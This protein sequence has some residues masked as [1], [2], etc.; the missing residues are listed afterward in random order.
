MSEVEEFS[1]FED[2]SVLE[3]RGICMA[4]AELLRKQDRQ[5]AEQAT[6]IDRL[7]AELAEVAAEVRRRRRRDSRNSGNSS[8]PPSSD[9]VLPGRERPVVTPRKPK[10][11]PRKRGRQPGAPGSALAWGEPT[12]VVDHRPAGTCGGCGTSLAGAG[13]DV[14]SRS[15]QVI[16]V[17]L[18]AMT[19][20][21]HRLHTVVCGCGRR[22]T[23]PTPAGTPDTRVSYGPNLPAL[24]VYL[25]VAHALPVE[26]ACQVIADLTG[27]RPS[28]SFAH[29]TLA[30]TAK[31]LAEPMAAIA[32]GLAASPVVHFDE[33]GLRVGP[34]PHAAQVWVAATDRY[35]IY[36]LAS[37]TGLAFHAWGL[38]K[39][40][41]DM[42]IVHDNFSV[43]DNRAH[44]GP[45]IR[46]QLCVAHLLRHLVD[47]EQ[48]YP[49]A[50][51]PTTIATALRGLIHAHHVARD[52]GLGAIPHQVA[53]PLI[54]A[55]ERAVKRGL[56]QLP[57]PRRGTPPQSRH[58]LEL[59][60]D[61]QHDVLRFCADT[62]IPPTNNQAERDLRPFKTQQ[63]ISGRLTS[64]NITEHRLTIRG[65]L[66]TAVKHGQ[67]AIT[68][69]RDTILGR[70]WIPLPLIAGT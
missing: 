8:L 45:D 41:R 22:A 54:G 52:Q 20:T 37:R 44:F 7:R 48:T 49:T 58:L 36:H 38:G 69:L 35:T 17:P 6:T 18:I 62:R 26:R 53:K 67:R 51:W 47:A 21:E 10:A 61:R 4:Q 16:D 28:T 39:R 43:Y 60:R 34:P 70:P 42:V 30:R 64:H 68:V 27:V 19:V 50:R 46:H 29:G 15:W 65:Y 56:N 12:E 9:G 14:V 13:E 32:L 11:E 59:L 33:T 25:M 3:L 31:A 2:F 55:Y 40:L 57:R 66:S 5:L 63:K 1:T 24:L 23:A